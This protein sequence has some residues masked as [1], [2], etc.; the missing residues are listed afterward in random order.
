MNATHQLPG[1]DVAISGEF[2][3]GQLHVMFVGPPRQH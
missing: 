3:P 2:I 1:T